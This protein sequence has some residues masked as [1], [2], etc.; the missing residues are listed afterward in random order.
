MQLSRLRFAPDE[1]FFKN[2]QLLED[3]LVAGIGRFGPLRDLERE[4]QE[5]RLPSGRRID[6]LCRERRR[7]GG[8]TSLRSS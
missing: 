2:E 3:F 7:D 6:I 1:L 8:V 5:F 4:E